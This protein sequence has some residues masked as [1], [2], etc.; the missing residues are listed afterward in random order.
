MSER[1]T[2]FGYVIAARMLATFIAA[3][4]ITMA[5]F[6]ILMGAYGQ[7]VLGLLIF[8]FGAACGYL[9]VRDFADGKVLLP[10][11]YLERSRHEAAFWIFFCVYCLLLP[12]LLAG[13][14]GYLMGF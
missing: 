2:G 8:L 9:L 14:A 7:A 11:G 10:H 1:R 5:M 3:I 4:G 12:L 13:T 6:L